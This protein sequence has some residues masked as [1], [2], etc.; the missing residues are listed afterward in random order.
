ME[1]K[2]RVF[3]KEEANHHKIMKA[4]KVARVLKVEAGK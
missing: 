2:Q 1:K 3:S 4:I